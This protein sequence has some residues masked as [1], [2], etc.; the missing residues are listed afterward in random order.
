[1]K[2][3]IKGWLV[4]CFTFAV[5]FVL[6]QPCSAAEEQ[7]LLSADEATAIYVQDIEITGN[8]LVDTNLIREQMKTKEGYIFDRDAVMGD[9]NNIYQTGYFTKKIRALPEKVDDE[10]VRLKITVEE[11]PPVTGFVVT[12]NTVIPTAEIIKILEDLK[13]KPQNIVAINESTEKIAELYATRGYILARIEKIE[14]DPDGIL[15]L[16]ITEGKINDII[17]EGDFK[18]KDYV[19]K[20]NIMIEPGMIYNENL[21]RDDISRLMGTQAFKD[22]QR[23]I[24]K[25]PETGDY[26]ITI[27]LEEQRT[28][29]VS[30]GVGLDSGSGF[31]GNV[32]FAENN[33]LGLG[34]KLSLSLMAG[35]GILMSD[36]SVIHRPNFQL[37]AGWYEPYFKSRENSLGAR[38][39]YRDYASFQIPQAIERRFGGEV[40]FSRRLKTY[41]NLTASLGLKFENVNVEEGDFGKIKALYDAHNVPISMRDNQLEGGA[42]ISLAPSLVYDTRD[43]LVNPRHGVYATA[44]LEEAVN[45][46]SLEN[47]YGKL[48]GALRKFV[49]VGKKSSLVLTAS[50]GGLLNGTM[51]EAMQFRLGGPYT[52]RG[53]NMAEVGT[54]TGYMMGSAE[55][56]VPVPFIDRLTSNTFL[57]NIR[58]AAFVDAGKIFNS[59]VT[60]RLYERPG[61]AITA[62]AGIRLFIPGIGPLSLDYGIPFTGGRGANDGRSGFFTF[63]IGEMLY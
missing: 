28:G 49:P 34:Q 51:P 11:N 31:F 58:L 18:T 16:R 2:H 19:V 8:N 36:D 53:F 63:G 55:L 40:T 37:E 42:F 25:D 35:T 33:L 17:V 44:Q 57:N 30:L 47:S 10:T 46:K 39:F 4:I 62:G 32:G 60:D 22:V 14:D 48:T 27:N 56:R 9:L 54:G 7:S 29:T 59:S 38:L 23:S 61:Y 20:R 45:I 12:G 50:A 43:S 6:N 3:I 5:L 21:V 52:I 1:M 41:K 15:N 26:N 13:G 24:E